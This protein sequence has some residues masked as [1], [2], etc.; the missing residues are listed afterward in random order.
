MDGRHPPTLNGAFGLSWQHERGQ[1]MA[2]PAILI[3]AI[4]N[5]PSS[6]RVHV[7]S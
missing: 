2:G 5:G 3:P 7:Y 1:P 4:A 6:G